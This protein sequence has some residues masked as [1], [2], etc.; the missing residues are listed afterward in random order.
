VS[1]ADPARQVPTAPLP[2][3]AVLLDWQAAGTAYFERTVRAF[4]TGGLGAPS[5]LPGWS[6]AHVVAHVA[7][8]ADALVNLLTWAG[9]GVET[10]MYADAETRERDIERGAR[11][12]AGVLVADLQRAN[13]RY[14]RAVAELPGPAWQATV[15]TRQGRPVAATAVP[16]MR[17]CEVWVHA[18]DLD[19]AAGF[20]GLPTALVTAL[21]DA[22]VESIGARGGGPHLVLEEAGTDRRFDLVGDGPA[23]TVR[24]SLAAL[25]G[26]LLRGRPDPALGSD[27]VLPP[28]PRWL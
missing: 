8:N 27:A 3:H 11:Q 7:R 24:G 23:T 5:A 12:P 16:W 6:R 14:A 22:A 28:A 18:I 19:P 2:P 25:A 17:A 13:A 10:P 15:R 1:A 26:Y 21:L 9:T 4:G 20:A